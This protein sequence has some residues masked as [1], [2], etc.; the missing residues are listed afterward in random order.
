MLARKI[1][2][3]QIEEAPFKINIYKQDDNVSIECSFPTVYENFFNLFKDKKNGFKIKATEE[4]FALCC[5]ETNDPIRLT[6][7]INLLD[8]L[9]PGT[10]LR[11]QIINFITYSK[12]LEAIHSRLWK[13]Q[14]EGNNT[15]PQ[16]EKTV[17]IKA[18]FN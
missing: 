11:A 3:L 16:A 9:K 17:Q 10:N 1:T 7:F 6:T 4:G 13:P 5:N 18:N 15:T 8:S 2:H 14:F 12:P